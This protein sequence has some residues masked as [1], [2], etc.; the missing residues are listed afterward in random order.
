M[1]SFIEFPGSFKNKY[2][3]MCLLLFFTHY[4][5]ST[6]IISEKSVKAEN[7]VKNDSDFILMKQQQIPEIVPVIKGSLDKLIKDS[8]IYPQKALVDRVEGTIF[9]CFIVNEDKTIS[10]FMVLK[11][12]R[13]DL[14]NEALRIAKML[15]FLNPASQ[16]GRIIKYRYCVPIKFQLNKVVKR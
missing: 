13:D 1:I 12:I 3:Y 16:N 5:C 6:H 11:G 4:S 7:L 14:N 9:I 15:E 8:L 10:D 2:I